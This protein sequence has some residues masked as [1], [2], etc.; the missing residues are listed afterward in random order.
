MYCLCRTP[1]TLPE[2]VAAA[3]GRVT[4]VFMGI[5][6]YGR[7]SYGGGG[8]NVDVAL[9]AVADAGLSAALFAPG[10]VYENLDR[11]Q[12]VTLQEQWWNKVS[13]L[14]DEPT[15]P[16]CWLLSGSVSIEACT[17][18]CTPQCT[19]IAILCKFNQ[20][21]LPHARYGRPQQSSGGSYKV[22]TPITGIFTG[23]VTGQQKRGLSLVHL[24]V[25]CKCHPCCSVCICSRPHAEGAGVYTSL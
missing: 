3:A 11:T 24:C 19:C 22:Y 25:A 7:G 5:D 21:T 23:I 1:A 12:F 18:A 8:H 2:T 16:F 13:W 17:R 9:R 15:S 14:V 6:V 20:G 4:D 10:W